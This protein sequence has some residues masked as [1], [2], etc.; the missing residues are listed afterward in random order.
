MKQDHTPAKPQESDSAHQRRVIA[1]Q[2]R[3]IVMSHL[4]AGRGLREAWKAGGYVAAAATDESEI[5]EPKKP[6]GFV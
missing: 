6:V 4:A 1:H 3:M 5:G 2:R